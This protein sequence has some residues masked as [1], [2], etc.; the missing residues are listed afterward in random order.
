MTAHLDRI[1][2]YAVRQR[3]AKAETQRMQRACVNFRTFIAPPLSTGH[4]CCWRWWIGQV[5]D[6]SNLPACELPDRGK[7][8]PGS[9][10]GE[11]HADHITLIDSKVVNQH[12]GGLVHPIAKTDRREFGALAGIQI[13]VGEQRRRTVAADTLPQS[14]GKQ[15]THGGQPKSNQA[16]ADGVTPLPFP[17]ALCADHG[18][19]IGEAALAAVETRHAQA[20]LTDGR[21]QESVADRVRAA[22][23]HRFARS[24]AR[25][26]RS[27]LRRYGCC[28]TP[29][30]EARQHPRRARRP[31]FTERRGVARSG[32]G[33][34][35]P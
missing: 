4:Y 15:W 5:H 29:R 33:G 19:R 31:R 12:V 1:I 25:L 18:W 26:H 28:R 13:V 30:A 32:S 23:R 16:P 6:E 21:W 14:L 35:R 20:A 24:G 34:A 11:R 10:N 7:P 8:M 22:G 17:H 9:L 27:R 3:L 2:A